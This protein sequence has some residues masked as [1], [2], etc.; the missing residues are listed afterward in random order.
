MA[1]FSRFLRVVSN[2]DVN[3]PVL[4]S[5]MSQ[6]FIVWGSIVFFSNDP[7]K[8]LLRKDAQQLTVFCPIKTV[9]GVIASLPA[10]DKKKTLWRRQQQIFIRVL[11][12]SEAKTACDVTVCRKKETSKHVVIKRYQCSYGRT[13]LLIHPDFPTQS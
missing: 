6:K 1:I 8:K 13:K 5:E 4:W 12:L 3:P 11:F 7:A 9:F 10:S 2:P